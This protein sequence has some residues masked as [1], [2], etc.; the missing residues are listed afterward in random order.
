[1]WCNRY[2]KSELDTC[3]VEKRMEQ[4]EKNKR[5]K[6]ASNKMQDK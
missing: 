6:K 4:N 1:M 3:N 5:N 2:K